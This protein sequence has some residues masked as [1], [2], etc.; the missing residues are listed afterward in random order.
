ML[1][2]ILAVTDLWHPTV[3]GTVRMIEQIDRQL[4]IMGHEVV[5]IGPRRFQTIPFPGDSEVIVALSPEKTIGPM[6]LAARPDAIHLWTAGPVG[7]AA[8]NIL[9]R[10]NIPFTSSYVTKSPEYMQARFGV[11]MAKTFA[12]LHVFHKISRC[13]MVPSDGIIDELKAR[14]FGNNLRLWQAG[15]DA[16]LFRPREKGFL[17]LPRPIHLNVG[18]VT[19]EKNLEA[20]LRLDLPGSKLVVGDGP[21]R[22]RLQ[23]Q[24][25]AV[26]FVGVKQG[27]ELAKY[28][29]AADV[30]VF[31]SRTDTLGLV[32]MESLAAGVPVAAFPVTGPNE[33]IAD[34]GAGV[35][36]ED[37][38][39][40]IE[41]ARKIDP[42]HCRAYAMRFSWARS[43]RDFLANLAP[44][45]G[46]V[47]AQERPGDAPDLLN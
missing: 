22:A 43:A 36:D 24:F 26:H 35:L 18:R 31:P 20:F 42:A 10:R 39:K 16:E 15:T 4:E 17:D 6:M 25:P 1:L 14:G 46:S 13:L 45:K 11:P 47:A 21:E 38:G 44:L 28:Y 29:A 8:R 7:V 32:M 37:L 33:V 34:G 23:K 12:T 30:F 40:A 5:V 3:N 27:E 19:I 41:A 2:R 9:G